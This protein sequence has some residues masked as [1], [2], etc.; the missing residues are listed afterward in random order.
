TLY[1]K[2]ES[3]IPIADA[4]SADLMVKFGIKQAGYSLSSISTAD[5]TNTF[6]TVKSYLATQ[7]SADVNP[8]AG[9]GV[10]K[11][12]DY[13]ELPSLRVAAYN[14]N[15]G[16]INIT[17]NTGDGK[18]RL[19]VV[20]INPYYGKNGNTVT[21][22]LVFQ[23]KDY[24]GNGRINASGTNA[25][26]YAASEMRQYLINEYLPG[27]LTA[28]VPD[29]AIWAVK[30][31]VA[32]G[33]IATGADAIEDKLW[34]PTER[35]MFG[36][37]TNSNSTHES[38]A[39]QGRL[40]YYNDDVGRKK[41]NVYLT[42][43][44]YD[45]DYY[46]CGITDNGQPI[47][48]INPDS[49][50]GVAPAFAVSGADQAPTANIK[51]VTYNANGGT[52]SA[53]QAV[54][55]GR[56][57]TVRDDSGF[58]RAGYYFDGWSTNTS[59]SGTNYNAGDTISSVT[60]NVT[61]YAKW[62]SGGVTLTYSANGGTTGDVPAQQTVAAGTFV[63]IAPGRGL[64]KLDTTMD[65]YTRYVS[66]VGWNTKEDGS[67][68]TYDVDVG[69]SYRLDANLTLY[70]QYKNAD[71]MVTFNVKTLGYALSSI[72]AADVTATFN[73]VST[74][75]KTKSASSV[76][77]QGG[78]GVI[79]MG[80][81][82]ELPSL[83]VAEYNGNWGNVSLTS[84]TGDGK[85]RVM[86]VGINSYYN[87]NGNGTSTPHLIFHFRNIPWNVRME[88]TDTNQNG[89]AGSEMRKF[90]TPLNGVSGSGNFWTGLKNAGVPENVVWKISRRVTNSA[91]IVADTIEDY[92]WLPTEWEM[93]GSN[94]TNHETDT[95]QGR[96]A[97]YGSRS[98]AGD[99]TRGR[100]WIASLS[101]NAAFKCVEDWGANIYGIRAS[102]VYTGCVPA[103]A[104]K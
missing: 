54:V 10:I 58:N 87:K 101:G 47:R 73:R 77:P 81:Y 60:T 62:Q 88:A 83:S 6:N 103:F 45:G 36:S 14:S 70:A 76:N 23:F 17:S 84:N 30:R 1:A 71:L 37:N 89:Y 31:M 91:A 50:Y 19:M 4:N 104:V 42:A 67:G 82:V 92:L 29:S 94:A 39:N 99:A 34:L 74:Y 41:A 46:W 15:G 25:G 38:D 21:Q 97:Y 32:N 85:L 52:G 79:Q 53:S 75:I 7:N 44:P 11:L 24:P 80:D 86:V 61:L 27:L 28:G 16:G 9:L 51:T 65:G 3:A 26:G 56:S 33:G 63:T 66:F 12:G 2:W 90:L 93:T 57:V 48:W 59:G 5:V 49:S 68:F 55:S 8:A 78:L 64:G 18:L 98:K 20:G 13:V 22:H 35:E 72:S 43:S 96:F 95:N 69:K 102:D 40:G 100:Y